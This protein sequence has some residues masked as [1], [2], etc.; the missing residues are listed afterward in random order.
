ME[1]LLTFFFFGFIAVVLLVN[2]ARTIRIVPQDT[3]MQ[4]ERLRRF[5]EVA[6]SGLN[7]LVP[8]LER[9]RAVYWTNTRPGMTSIDLREQYID[10][11][12]Q[13]VITRDNVTI[14]VD[15]VVYWQITDPIKAVYEMNDLIG[16]IVQLTITGMRAV[17]GD[18]DLDHTLSNRDQINGKLRMIL[19]E[20]TDKW[21]VKVTRVDVKNINPPEDVRITMEKQMTAERNRRAL[22]LTA[23]GDKQAA[24]TR[25]EGNKQSAILDAE[26]AS[27][28]RLVNATAEAQAIA[29][30]ASAIGD[31]GQ[32]AQYLITSRYV[33]SMRDMAR[34]QNSKV[35]FMPMETSGVLASVGA[36]KEVFSE[37][38][39]RANELP[40]PRS[41]K[42]LEK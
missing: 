16:G 38:S 12:P 37:M 19:D 32:T 33:D 35:I 15:S 41:P 24:I 29:Q 2:A 18:M 39:E 6:S 4:V 34:T 31:R 5:D 14:H 20:A 36:F 17:M 25:A 9:P 22:I 1:F 27:Q 26:G 40:K 7:I 13:P 42:E 3:V 10:L 23:E 30:I 28:A 11:P 8:F 21:G